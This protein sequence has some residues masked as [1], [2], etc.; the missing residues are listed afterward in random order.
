MEEFNLQQRDSLDFPNFLFRIGDKH[1]L[2]C[3]FV[4]FLLNKKSDKAVQSHDITEFCMK[5]DYLLSCSNNLIF[6]SEAKPT[7]AQNSVAS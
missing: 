4:R 5:D 2:T 1:N 6:F 7:H 3:N